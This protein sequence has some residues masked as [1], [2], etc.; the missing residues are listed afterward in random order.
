MAGIIG[1]NWKDRRQQVRMG[2]A[3][4]ARL[5]SVRVLDAS[6]QGAYSTVIQGLQWVLDHKAEHNIRIV[7]LSLHAEVVCPYFFDALDQAAEVVWR[8][9]I[10][11]V[12]A[13]GN[14]GPNPATIT[15]PGND[16]YIITV[17]AVHTKDT[18]GDRTDD[19]IAPFSA[20]GPTLDNFAKPDWWPRACA[21]A[22]C[23]R[24]RIARWPS[25]TRTAS[26]V[27]SRRHSR[28]AAPRR[29]RR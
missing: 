22:R 21:S 13:A 12:T 25:S 23:W 4:D 19:Y 2:I 20:S 27:R 18:P 11:V 24:R 29:R 28:S 1:S 15:A 5:L 26:S 7:N 8:N 16:P 14:M 9:G 6:G 17:G 3:P 10:V